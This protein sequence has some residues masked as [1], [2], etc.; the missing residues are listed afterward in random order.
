MY[1]NNIRYVV[2][3]CGNG[4]VEVCTCAWVAAIIFFWKILLNF[5]WEF[6]NRSTEKRVVLEKNPCLTRG[7]F[8]PLPHGAVHYKNTNQ[9]CSPE[10][11]FLYF[12]CPKEN[13]SILLNQC[14]AQLLDHVGWMRGPGL[15]CKLDPVGGCSAG[16]ILHIS[17]NVCAR[18]G[19]VPA[20]PHAVDTAGESLSAPV[21]SGLQGPHHSACIPQV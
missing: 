10:R 6:M 7:S 17:L 12:C 15:V 11:S 4:N 16:L 8:R 20:W 3:C 14:C 19:C 1:S 2:L 9:S 13:A 21:L 18:S 5:N